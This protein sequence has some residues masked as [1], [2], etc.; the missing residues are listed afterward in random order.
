[1]LILLSSRLHSVLY[2]LTT[3]LK[4]DELVIK[5][6]AVAEGH[7]FFDYILIAVSAKKLHL[8]NPL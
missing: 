2:K 7:T 4:A 3:A 6:E 1:M 5:F 8:S